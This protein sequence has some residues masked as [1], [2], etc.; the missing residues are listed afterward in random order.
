MVGPLDMPLVVHR[1]RVVAVDGFFKM[2]DQWLSLLHGD[3]LIES[4]D[5]L[6]VIIYKD[7]L[8]RLLPFKFVEDEGGVIL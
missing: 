7:G 1:S 6:Y 4:E 5:G 8:V 2:N 3:A